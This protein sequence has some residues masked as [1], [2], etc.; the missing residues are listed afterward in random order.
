[1]RRRFDSI[2]T[3]EP[4]L[5]KHCFSCHGFDEK[6]REAEL[7]L[8]TYEAATEDRGDYRAISP[9]KPA[10]SEIWLRI[11]SSDPDIVMPPSDSHPP[12]SAEEKTMLKQWIEQGAEYQAHWSFIPPQKPPVPKLPAVANPIDAFIQRRLESEG[13]SVSPAAAK[14]VLIRRVTLD[15]TGLPPHLTRNR[16]LSAGQLRFRVRTPRRPPSKSSGLWRA[17]GKGVAR[18]GTL[19][20]HPW[21]APR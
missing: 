15:L 20:G 7:R 11:N 18:S 6:K 9:G 16:R 3:Y 5:S 4:I 2:E 14:E 8:D 17:H 10:E 21:I 12:L 13:L 1:M 19:R